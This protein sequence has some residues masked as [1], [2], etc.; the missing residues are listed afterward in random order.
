LG[1]LENIKYS[2]GIRKYIDRLLFDKMVSSIILIFQ[3]MNLL[4][5]TFRKNRFW[6]DSDSI[7]GFR[8]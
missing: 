2:L 4:S 3:K 8:F 7:F 6:M 1:K 5:I